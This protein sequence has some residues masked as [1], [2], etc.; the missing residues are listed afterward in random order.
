MY[1]NFDYELKSVCGR[2]YGWVTGPRK[3]TLGELQH[4]SHKT[5]REW[6]LIMKREWSVY[7]EYGN[8]CANQNI[9]RGIC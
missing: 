1:S 5:K 9:R 7:P 6:M 2:P 4:K 3:D 8:A